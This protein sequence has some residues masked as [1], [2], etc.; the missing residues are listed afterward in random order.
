[1]LTRSLC[2]LASGVA[3]TML[4][5]PASAAEPAQEPTSFRTVEA[6]TFTA[7]DLQ[8]YGLTTEEVAKGVALQEQGYKIVAL[9]PEEAEAYRA[10]DISQNEWILIGIGVLIILAVA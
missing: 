3:L 4:A 2:A 8:R 6:Q 10:G 1:M 5:L 9:T 7:E